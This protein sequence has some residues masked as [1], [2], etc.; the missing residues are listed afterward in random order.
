MLLLTSLNQKANEYLVRYAGSFI[1]SRCDCKIR[2]DL[3]VF[4]QIEIGY[5]GKYFHELLQILVNWDE[6]LRINTYKDP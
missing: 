4:W 6:N 1:H 3:H 2:L 5:L